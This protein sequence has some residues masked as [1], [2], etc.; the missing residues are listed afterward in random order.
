VTIDELTPLALA[1]SIAFGLA[2]LIGATLTYHAA[3]VLFGAPLLAQAEDTL[4]FSFCAGMRGACGLSG[5]GKG[6]TRGMSHASCLM[7]MI[8][9][10][11]CP[12][13]VRSRAGGVPGRLLLWQP[14]GQGAE[15]AC[16][17]RPH[18]ADGMY[19][20]CAPPRPGMYCMRFEAQC[21]LARPARAPHRTGSS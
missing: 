9:P 10:L 21:L 12:P 7:H 8:H 19:R 20:K 1:K 17:P 5:E 11:H 14:G 3:F 13:N 15:R 2:Y 4:L 6:S 16:A 18:R